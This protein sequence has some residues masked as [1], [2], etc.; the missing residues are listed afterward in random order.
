[1]L[2]IVLATVALAGL[3][4]A[5]PPVFADP[6]TAM[7]SDHV[8]TAAPATEQP[9]SDRLPA[10]DARARAEADRDIVPVGLGWG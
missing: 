10:M 2:R 6:L 8:R 7:A 5:A 3:L 9:T 4:A 1:M